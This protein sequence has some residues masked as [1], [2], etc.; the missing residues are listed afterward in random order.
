MPLLSVR[1][2]YLQKRLAA[3]QQAVGIPAEL[4]ASVALAQPELLQRPLTAWAETRRQLK[5]WPAE[6]RSALAQQPAA[7]LASSL[8]DLQDAAG[9][10]RQWT[11]VLS[12]PPALPAAALPTAAAAGRMG[13]LLPATPP[14]LR[15]GAGGAV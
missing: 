11:Q 2:A 9:M 14:R 12:A 15:A 7:E 8:V 5:L 10:L 1:G 13:R 3:L 4:A 6:Q